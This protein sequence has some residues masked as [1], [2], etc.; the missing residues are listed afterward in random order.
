M[1]RT[2]RVLLSQ[3]EY[4]LLCLVAF[5]L[6]AQAAIVVPG[7]SVTVVKAGGLLLIAVVMARRVLC[8]RAPFA[9]TGIDGALALFALACALSIPGSVDRDASIR[10]MTLFVQYAVLFYAV[11]T[12]ISEPP[13]LR[14]FAPVFAGGAAFSGVLAVLASAELGVRPTVDMAT[15]TLGI[16]RICVGHPDANQQALFLVFGLACLLFEPAVWSTRIR[17]AAAI[18]GGIAI[19]AGLALTMSRTGW[20]I[21]AVIVLWRLMLTRHRMTFALLIGAIGAA[22]ALGL[23]AM[24]PDFIESVQRRVYEGAQA[25]DRSTASRVMHYARAGEEAVRGGWFGHGLDTAHAIGKDLTDPL[26]K[27]IGSTVHSVPISFW[28]E[29]GWFGLACFGWL[30]SAI[31]VQW[32]SAYRS[33]RDEEYKS[34]VFSTGAVTLVYLAFSQIMPFIQISGLAI[35]LGFVMGTINARTRSDT[36]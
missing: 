27:P 33:A 4:F 29:L 30:W 12:A 23:W 19:A 14:A 9:A 16:R 26:G 22:G 34:R 2:V 13:A 5:S 8:K 25:G 31:G 11:S 17:Q 7:T 6:P 21:S 32:V 20:A 36:N 24:K 1:L 35:L 28:I 10:G 15:L 3:A 18:L